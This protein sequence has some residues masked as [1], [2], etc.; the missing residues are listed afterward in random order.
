M[1]LEYDKNP[2]L[3]VEQ[4]LRSLQDSMQQA[5][6]EHENSLQQ[7]E[8]RTTNRISDVEGNISTL[9]QTSRSLTSRIADSEGNIS[10]LRQ[11]AA[12][13]TSRM[14]DAEG[15]ISSVQQT[16]SSLT[17][18]MGTA[19]GNISSVQQTASGLVSTVAGKVGKNEVI[20]CIN[21]SAESV[22]IS[23]SKVNIDASS[24]TITKLGS[25]S[26]FSA[27]VSGDQLNYNYNG[28]TYGTIGFP[29]GAQNLEFESW[30]NMR[31]WTGQNGNSG[32][33]TFGTPYALFNGYIAAEGIKNHNNKWLARYDSSA[34]RNAFGNNEEV[35]VIRGTSVYRAGSS[36]SFDSSSDIRLKK[37]MVPLDY[38]S[39]VVL[40]LDAFE[41]EWKDSDDARYD[42]MKHFGVSAQKVRQL[43]EENGLDVSEY[44]ML[45]ED[46]GYYT[47]TYG[48]FIPMLIRTVQDLHKEIEELKRRIS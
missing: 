39:G 31:F 17:T 8:D 27:E 46:D 22:T 40:N 24:L 6:D 12:S 11:T 38:A 14:G 13:L 1:I 47:L 44:A 43:F 35:S 3:S 25:N 41:F 19:E 16:A 18:R 4:Q 7:T 5:L 32:Q 36:T 23:A 34:S 20:S 26:G 33:I 30:W 37:N 42:T 48:D 10:I 2:N 15:N 9:E 45:G 21:Q 29:N 28:S